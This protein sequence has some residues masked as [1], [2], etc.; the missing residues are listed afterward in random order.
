MFVELTFCKS[1]K[2]GVYVAAAYHPAFQF[3]AHV[4]LRDVMSHVVTDLT[5]IRHLI[6]LKINVWG[7]RMARWVERAPHVQRPQSVSVPPLPVSL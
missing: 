6:Y 7:R 2:L 1:A 4:T 3:S 5:L